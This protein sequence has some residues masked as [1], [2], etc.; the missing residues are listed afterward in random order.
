[1]NTV[2]PNGGTDSANFGTLEANSSYWFQ[3]FLSAPNTVPGLK[4][5]ATL[6]STG[7]SPNYS[8]IRTDFS[9]VTSSSVT[10]MYGFQMMGTISTSASAL[11][12]S[13]RVIDSTGDSAPS[14]ITFSGTAYIAK[15]GSIS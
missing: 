4:V 15:V 11:S 13:I 5:G 7:A 14:G 2:T 6:S 10:S 12:F 1:L 3:I 8:V 9:K